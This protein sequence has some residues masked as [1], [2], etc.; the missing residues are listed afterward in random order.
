[1]GSSRNRRRRRRRKCSCSNQESGAVFI[2]CGFC[3][4]KMMRKQRKEKSK[5]FRKKQERNKRAMTEV[6]SGDTVAGQKPTFAVVGTTIYSVLPT[7]SSGMF[8]TVREWLNTGSLTDIV[9]LAPSIWSRHAKRHLR[10]ILD[11]RGAG[12]LWNHIVFQWPHETYD[13]FVLRVCNAYDV[14]HFFDVSKEPLRVIAVSPYHMQKLFQYRPGFDGWDAV[15][16]WISKTSP[17]YVPIHDKA[18]EAGVIVVGA[19]EETS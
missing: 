9:I 15:R 5:H 19:R 17:H 14:T 11:S 1:M 3:I 16:A 10:R 7:E 8:E 2:P 12:W 13:K 18:E 6:N 4:K